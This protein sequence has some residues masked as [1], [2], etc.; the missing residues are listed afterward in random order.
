MYPTLLYLLQVNTTYFPPP[1]ETELGG[2]RGVERLILWILLANTSYIPFLSSTSE[3]IK[4]I[5]RGH[6]LHT[7]IH[8]GKQAELG[9][10][11]VL[12]QS[13]YVVCFSVVVRGC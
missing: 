13:V 9:V 6:Y 3:I 5:E 1:P 12:N 7:K 10:S 2:E 4:L 11:V 8:G